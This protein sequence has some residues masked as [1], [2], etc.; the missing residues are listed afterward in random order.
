[1][2]EFPFLRPSV[3]VSTTKGVRLIWVQIWWVEV[4]ELAPGR[5]KFGP[6][7]GQVRPM[8]GNTFRDFSLLIICVFWLNDM[9]K[10]VFLPVKKCF[11]WL[12]VV[13]G[14]LNSIR[15]EKL[16]EIIYW[17][18][19]SKFQTLAKIAQYWWTLVENKWNTSRKDKSGF[20]GG[21]LEGN[22]KVEKFTWNHRG[23]TCPAQK[24]E[25]APNWLFIQNTWFHCFGLM[26][27]T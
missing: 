15:I 9:I 2:T 23:R 4:A 8:W 14:L 3:V 1:M 16:S 11:V 19:S 26:I 21:F 6:W 20:M 17:L 18:F 7:P 24:A 10:E 12:Y 13:N 22:K 5:G 27:H 25:L